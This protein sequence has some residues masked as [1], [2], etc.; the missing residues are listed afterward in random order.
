MAR[1]RAGGNSGKGFTGSGGSGASGAPAVL[2]F[3]N[4]TIR[5]YRGVAINAYGDDSDVGSIYLTGIPAAI[6]ETADVVFN[7]ATQ[8]QQIIRGVTCVVAAWVD[9]DDDDTIQDEATG[10]FYEIQSVEARPGI[11]YYPP[12]QMLTLMMRSGISVG[13]D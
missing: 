6:A 10:Y 5:T 8:R 13:S 12:D 7:A 3:R 2:K 1:A 11:G 9:I 4:R